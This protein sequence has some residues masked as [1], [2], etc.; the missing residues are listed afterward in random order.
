LPLFDP[1]DPVDYAL[2]SAIGA[3]SVNAS[4]AIRWSTTRRSV[5][6]ACRFLHLPEGAQAMW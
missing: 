3:W 5:D 2:P 6:R 4:S 1:G